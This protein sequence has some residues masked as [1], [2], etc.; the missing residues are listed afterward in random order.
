MCRTTWTVPNR[1]DDSSY[2]A[3]NFVTLCRLV[4]RQLFSLVESS[5]TNKLTRLQDATNC[6]G[7]IEPTNFPATHYKSRPIERD[8]LT[9][10]KNKRIPQSPEVTP[11]TTTNSTK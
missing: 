6:D 11:S 10:K 1:G 2:R 5:P 4:N 8:I 9:R 7:A 3:G